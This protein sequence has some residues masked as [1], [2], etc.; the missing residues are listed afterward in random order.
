MISGQI[1]QQV[2]AQSK[3][4]AIAGTDPA[5]QYM[6]REFNAQVEFAS[7]SVT[8]GDLS[9]ARFALRPALSY[10]IGCH[11]RS[12]QGPAFAISPLQKGLDALSS[13]DR[14]TVFAAT[15]Q[16][17]AALK[18]Y[19]NVL[20]DSN[21]DPVQIERATRLA[22]AVSVRAK[23]NPADALKVLDQASHSPG[24]P[25]STEERVKAWRSSVVSWMGEKA[26]PANET[27]L[28][29]A[30]ALIAKAEKKKSFAA[31]TSA[32]IEYLRATM[33]LHDFLKDNPAASDRAEAEYSIGQAYSVLR[34][35]GFWDLHEIYYEACV[36]D[37]PHSKRAESCFEKLHDSTVEGFT[38]SAGTYVPARVSQRLNELKE[39]AKASAPSGKKK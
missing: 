13:S 3:E 4:A 5:L 34:D 15:R 37:L 14:L 36:R 17:E 16:Y 35:L 32:D 28:S 8:A 33:L 38:G 24:L 1:H 26:R 31:D 18:E 23:Q 10:C 22:L 12:S 21:R 30:Q 29:A 25:S 39:M 2:K 20:K 7:E 27:K 19:T 6:A 11:T 9:R